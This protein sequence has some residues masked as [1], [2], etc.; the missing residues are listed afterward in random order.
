[1]AYIIYPSHQTQLLIDMRLFVTRMRTL[2]TIVIK[3][4]YVSQ[5]TCGRHSANA[6]LWHL[7][8]LEII[9]PHDTYETNQSSFA[10]STHPF[11]WLSFR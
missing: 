1:M 7:V 10:L 5:R 11:V 8:Q 4:T 2:C 3:V 6:S 9:R